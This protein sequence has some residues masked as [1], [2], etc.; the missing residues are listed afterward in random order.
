MRDYPALLLTFLL[1]VSCIAAEL[2]ASPDTGMTAPV[3]TIII[4][5]DIISPRKGRV[6]PRLAGDAGGIALV[7]SGGGA[8]GLSQIGVLAEL[9][10]NGIR[11]DL[12][13]GTS[14]GAIV[15]GLYAA[16][17]TPREL[18]NIA[19]EIDWER[20]F[21]DNPERTKLFLTQRLATERFFLHIRFSGLGFHIPEGLTEAQILYN[22]LIE[23]CAPADYASG[24][25]F[26]NL[27][28]SFR[29]VTTDLKTGKTYVFSDGNLAAV[30]RASAAVPLLLSPMETD[31]ALLADGGLVFPIPVEI[32]LAE[33]AKIIIAVDATAEVI[34]PRNL[35]NALYILDQMTNIMTEE[36]KA[37]ERRTADIVITPEFEGHG[38][39]DFSRIDWLIEQ[40]RLAT[41]EILPELSRLRVRDGNGRENR[42]FD[43]KR[44]S[45]NRAE[46]MG[47]A[48]GERISLD[49]IERLLENLYSRGIY[50]SVEARVFIVGDSAEIE[51]DIRQNPPLKGIDIEGEHILPE[52]SLKSFFPQNAD[53]PANL[54][55]LDSGLVRIE[56]YYHREGY[57]LA[58]ISRANFVDS[59]F[60]L[61]I[62]EGLIERVEMEGNART[63]DWV[64]R[65]FI[66]IS[67]GDRYIESRIKRALTDLHATGLFETVSPEI[68]RGDSAAVLTFHVVEKPY[69]GFRLGARYDLVNGVEGAIEIGDDNIFG[70]AWRL[71]LGAF[72]GERRW[73]VYTHLGGDRI[74]RTYLTGQLALFGSGKEYDI[75]TGD[76]I[77]ETYTIYRYGFST[78]LGQQIKRLGTVFVEIGTERVAFGLQDDKLKEY[79]LHRFTL[80]S[81]VDTF[82]DRQFPRSGKYHVSYITFSRDILGGAYSFTKTYAG[83]Q[84][85]WTWIKPL[86]FRPYIMGGY[87][88][89]GPPFFEYFELGDA[90]DFW[91]LRGDELRGNSFVK[92]G[93]ELRLNPMAPVYIIAG[94]SYGRT[95]EKDAKLRLEDMIWGWGA[96][97]GIATPLG[98]IKL[99]WG[100]NTEKLEEVVFSVGY[101]FE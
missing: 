23:L 84:S 54:A 89:G 101:N 44:I 68:S 27:R 69:S 71:N 49:L 94:I 41:K 47:I 13:V 6:W 34:Y 24:G 51:V 25:D 67:D 36:K 86:T 60:E 83:F 9:E 2:S 19:R 61:N 30:L 55:L 38:S 5:P 62:N 22:K 14:I 97:W 66:P 76:E 40:G 78:I 26:D 74:W 87:M 50:R 10:N 29:A 20:L 8:R 17:Y 15:G 96:G 46:L 93:F 58:H 73:S 43:I 35:D 16:G 42:D 37:V 31:S 28:L 48:P 90:I 11:P 45:G 99:T 21:T 85:Y 88:A 98:P 64:I 100:R 92:T 52:D 32:A 3:D 4:R 53:E 70:S 65:S 33:S 80:R 81:I 75:W 57:S 72:G 95:W 12:V 77:S 39:F 56:E 79:Q 91:G 18:E 82:N 7:L 59:I 63:R 1:A